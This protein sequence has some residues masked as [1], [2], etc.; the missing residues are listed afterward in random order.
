MKRVI[1][2]GIFS[3]LLLL[4]TSVQLSGP[5]TI[6]KKGHQK[7]YVQDGKS[8]DAKKLA[9]MLRS[10]DASAKNYSISKTN[11]IVAVS[12]MGVGTVFFGIGFI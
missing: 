9:S 3:F 5:I 7:S 2:L 6:E 12:S 1:L 8:L 10:D 11:S 4:G